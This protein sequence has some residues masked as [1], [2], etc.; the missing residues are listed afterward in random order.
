M[1]YFLNIHVG[2]NAK[3]HTPC[4]IVS[5]VC[6]LF[7]VRRLYVSAKCKENVPFQSRLHCETSS[8]FNVIFLCRASETSSRRGSTAEQFYWR[9]FGAGTPCGSLFLALRVFATGPLWYDRNLSSVHR[10]DPHICVLISGTQNVERNC[11][12]LQNLFDSCRKIL[13]ISNYKKSIKHEPAL[14]DIYLCCY[15]PR[16]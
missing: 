6:E 3:L 15:Y 9:A 4:K 7:P 2:N 16:V 5:T 1:A 13:I 10:P 8:V 14:T 12:F 11:R